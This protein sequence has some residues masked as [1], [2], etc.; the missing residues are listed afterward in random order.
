[1]KVKQLVGQL[2][3]T[4]GRKSHSYLI[5]LLND[6]LDEI[7]QTALNNTEINTTQLA[8]DQR[9]YSLLT[10]KMIDVF[11]VEVLDSKL[12]WRQIPRSTDTP[13][14]GDDE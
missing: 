3:H 1:M 9:W 14:I 12:K 11:R 6:G 13:E 2:E 8:K 4:F 7:A 10:S 5:S